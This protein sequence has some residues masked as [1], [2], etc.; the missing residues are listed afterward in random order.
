MRNKEKTRKTQHT[1]DKRRRKKG[2]QGPKAC[3]PLETG[4]TEI[5]TK[6]SLEIEQILSLQEK[7]E[8]LEK[9]EERE[10]KIGKNGKIEEKETEKRRKKKK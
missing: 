9:K 10:R 5:V 6:L 2:R 8:R 4:P 1:G 3:L 7:K